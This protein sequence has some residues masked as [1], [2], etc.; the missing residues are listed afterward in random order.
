[1]VVIVVQMG[2][3]QKPQNF[4][5]DAVAVA[6]AAVAVAGEEEETY[7]HYPLLFVAEM[8]VKMPAVAEA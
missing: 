4:A 7:S 2:R 8:A 1:M 3:L 6:V 5:G